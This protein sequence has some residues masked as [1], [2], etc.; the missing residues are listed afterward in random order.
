MEKQLFAKIGETW[1]FINAFL[2]TL[3]LDTKPK[4]VHVLKIDI[5]V[6]CLPKYLS[7]KRSCVQTFSPK[8]QLSV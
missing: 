4:K 6:R 2:E 5:L 8:V 7:K 3:K 1:V